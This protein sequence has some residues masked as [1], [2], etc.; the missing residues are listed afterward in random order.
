M[1]LLI[2]RLGRT[3]GIGRSAETGNLDME[4]DLPS[5]GLEPLPALFIIGPLLLAMYAGSGNNDISRTFQWYMEAIQ[6]I[7]TKEI[8]TISYESSNSLP[9]IKCGNCPNLACE[10]ICSTWVHGQVPIANT[11]CC[12][13]SKMPSYP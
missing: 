8:A 6:P 7:L 11:P 3:T 1:N 12:S 2:K 13:G 4:G 10:T 5:S 9:S